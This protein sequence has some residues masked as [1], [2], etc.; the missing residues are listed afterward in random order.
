MMEKVIMRKIFAKPIAFVKAH[1][2]VDIAFL[3]AAVVTYAA[4]TLGNVT[5]AAIWFDEAFSSYL[6][7]FNFFD[8]CL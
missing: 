7:Q 1:P 6:I 4:V 2:K 3:V 8:I 5:N